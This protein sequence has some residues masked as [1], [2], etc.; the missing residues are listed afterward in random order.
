VDTD[1]SW[2][3]GREAVTHEVYLS[4]D[5]AAVTE[6]TALVDTVDQSNYMP[7]SL[8][9]GHTYYWKVVEVNET[10]TPSVWPGNLW[11]FTT[12]QYV[13][14]DD[15]ESYDD[16]EN[17]IFDTWLDG[18]VNDTGMTVGYFESPFAEQTIVYDGRQSMPLQYDNSAAPFY[19]EAER[20]L[21]SENWSRNG[22]DTLVVHFRGNP[23]AFL[24]QADGMIVMGAAGADI[25]GTADEF[26]FAYK[27]LNGDGSIVARVDSL[28][29]TDP[30]AKGGVMIRETLDEGSKFAAVYITPGNGCRFQARQ[31]VSVPAVSDTSVATP[32]QIAVTAPYWVKLERAGDQFNGFYSAHGANWTAMSWNPQDVSM[33]NTVYIGLALTSHSAGNPTSAQFSGLATTGNV[34]GAWTADAIGVEQPSNDPAPL[35]VAVEDTA[36]NVAVVTHPDP[37]AVGAATWQQWLIPYSDLTGVNLSRVAF[38]YIGVGDRDNPTADGA[39]LIFVDD[40]AYGHPATV[41]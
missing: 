30:W 16:E 19:S 6:G 9:F 14:I 34:T 10:A 38:M 37:A 26:R 32:E 13:L 23:V 35:Y 3:A 15:M 1:L 25:W 29:D 27:Q 8:E 5:E 4:T 2:R 39:G 40:I 28:I 17:R 33:G 7:T 21:G 36:G 12:E 22:A 11:T 24:E 31:A 41:E 18:F 20:N